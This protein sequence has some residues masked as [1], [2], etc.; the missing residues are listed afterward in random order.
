M[1]R[2]FRHKGIAAFFR[3]GS[4]AGI[5]AMHAPRLR[6]QLGRLDSSVVPDDM[7]L[8]GWKFHKLQGNLQGH[9]AV[10]VNRNW[11]L[12]FAFEN[13]HAVLVDYQDYH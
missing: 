11:R 13:G 10:T 5:Q 2:S 8:P 6:L 1:I 9:Y 4:K 7:N 3:T 12:T